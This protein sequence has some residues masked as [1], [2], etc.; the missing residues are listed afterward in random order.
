MSQDVYIYNRLGVGGFGLGEYI[1]LTISKC[2]DE[3]G[4][5]DTD[6]KDLWKQVLQ[7]VYDT[8]DEIDIQKWFSGFKILV[9]KIEDLDFFFPL[10]RHV[11]DESG[12]TYPNTPDL[13][14]IKGLETPLGDYQDYDEIFDRAISVVHELWQHISS[15]V[16]NDDHDALDFI[17]DW[18]LDTGVVIGGREMTAWKKEVIRELGE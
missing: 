18:S 4:N 3:Q 13:T 2:V 9:D 6:I 15:F 17:Q 1:D 12:V 5:I 7:D 10:A 14:Y 8:R 16:Y 11:S